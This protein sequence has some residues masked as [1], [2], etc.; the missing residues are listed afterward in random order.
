M[1]IYPVLVGLVFSH[2]VRRSEDSQNLPRLLGEKLVQCMSG[3]ELLGKAREAQASVSDKDFM[4]YFNN[5]DGNND[6]FVD[7]DEIFTVREASAREWPTEELI[8]AELEHLSTVKAGHEQTVW[9][10]PMDFETYKLYCSLYYVAEQK[11]FY[12]EDENG[13]GDNEWFNHAMSI[14]KF[15]SEESELE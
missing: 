5:L 13:S 6:S 7:L 2:V 9:G 8:A 1:K 15:I 11:V 10:E 4:F 12:E 14:I 3:Q